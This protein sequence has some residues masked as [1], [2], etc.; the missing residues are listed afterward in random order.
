MKAFKVF[1][2]DWSCRPGS[3]VFH[4]EV[5]K[6]YEHT[7]PVVPCQSGF[8]ACLKLDDC[9]SYYNFNPD[10]KV[11]EVEVENYLTHDDDS[12]VA[13]G[14]ITIVR[15]LSWQEVLDLVNTG[16]NNTGKNNSGNGNS[17]DGN[18]GHGNSGDGNSG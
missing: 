3:N 5:G 4:F 11:A 6:T 1:N 16:K 9:F 7:G 12:K 15:E 8:H 18:S 13:A 2:P 17:G 14:R 10:N